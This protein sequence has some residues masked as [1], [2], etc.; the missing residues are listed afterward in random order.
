MGR[1][2]ARRAAGRSGLFLRAVDFL[3]ALEQRD[4]DDLAAIVAVEAH[5]GVDH[6]QEEVIGFLGQSDTV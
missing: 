2:S 1:A 6:L 5:T 4:R 3:A